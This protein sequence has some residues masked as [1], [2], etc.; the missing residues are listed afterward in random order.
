MFVT[1]V[2]TPTKPRWRWRI[3]SP[4]GEL[5][6]E[7]RDDFATISAA[8]QAGRSRAAE[9]DT[10]VRAPDEPDRPPTWRRWRFGR[11]GNLEERGP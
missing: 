4:A 7:S 1:A 5:V 2:S 6:D 11:R 8:L 10:V 9:I 3:T